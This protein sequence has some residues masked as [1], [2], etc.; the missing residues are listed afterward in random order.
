MTNPRY[1]QA[2]IFFIAALSVA[3]FMTRTGLQA[4]LRF[5]YKN[6]PD[7]TLFR[8]IADFLQLITLLLFT[9]FY[10]LNSF[11]RPWF[12]LC[13]TVFFLLIMPDIISWLW[14]TA[15]GP[16]FWNYIILYSFPLV[17]LLFE[18]AAEGTIRP[19][20]LR[21]FSGGFL[22]SALLYDLLLVNTGYSDEMMAQTS[23]QIAEQKTLF[24][25][26][27]MGVVSGLTYALHRLVR[28]DAGYTLS[29]GQS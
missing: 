3:E 19:A 8:T 29:T 12:Q 22:A 27:F 17:F 2:A 25:L 13:V 26:L 21:Y 15:N 11:I 10:A 6:F 18:L 24:A 5:N 4:T 9:G 14:L 28:A 20:H 16:G 1:L 23:I 7:P